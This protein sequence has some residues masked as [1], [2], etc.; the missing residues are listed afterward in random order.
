MANEEQRNPNPGEEKKPGNVVPLL[1]Y[2]LSPH[3][4]PDLFLGDPASQVFKL[5]IEESSDFR[6]AE[7][8]VEMHPAPCRSPHLRSSWMIHR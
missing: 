5:H 6:T 2:P 3:Q 1:Y 8:Q 4:S 7:I